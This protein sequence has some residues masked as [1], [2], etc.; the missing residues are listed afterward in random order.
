[1]TQLKGDE[2][3]GRTFDLVGAVPQAIH[4]DSRS[5]IVVRKPGTSQLFAFRMRALPFGAIRSVH[6]FLR[7]VTACGT[8]W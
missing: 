1:M 5:H 3:L 6:A 7:V 8:S 4:P 2:W